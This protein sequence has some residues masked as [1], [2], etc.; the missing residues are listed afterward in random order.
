MIYRQRN[1]Y[2]ITDAI[3]KTYMTILSISTKVKMN[4]MNKYEILQSK[5]DEIS[6]HIDTIHSEDTTTMNYL[7][8]YKDYVDRLI[9]AVKERTIRNS[10][11]ALMGLIR[12]IS[13]YDELCA[14]EILFQL[15]SDADN[16]Y[17]NECKVF[18]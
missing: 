11:G 16:Y 15:A 6:K 14:D 8:Q 1:I 9:V 7:K 12:G 13:D 18:D 10:N 5:L 4:I 17:C 3:S 2:D